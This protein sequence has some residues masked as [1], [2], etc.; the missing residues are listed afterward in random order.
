M[1][2]TEVRVSYGRTVNLGQFQSERIDVAFGAKVAEGETADTVANALFDK[3]T[4]RVHA[5]ID[6]SRQDRERDRFSAP[7]DDDDDRPF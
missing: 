5:Y 7:A 4:A 3:A 1:E 2:I 6:Q